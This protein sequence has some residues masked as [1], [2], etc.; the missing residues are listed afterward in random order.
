MTIIFILFIELLLYTILITIQPNDITIPF[1]EFIV[2][3]IH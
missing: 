3:T 1:N 2:V